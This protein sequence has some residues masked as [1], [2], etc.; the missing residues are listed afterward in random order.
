MAALV[1]S[2]ASAGSR[3]P[4]HGLTAAQVRA[5]VPAALPR[6]CRAFAEAIA[7]GADDLLDGA[8]LAELTSGKRVRGSTAKYAALRG[9][10][11]DTD[12]VAHSLFAKE[13]R[14]LCGSGV[15]PAAG[16]AGDNNE[17]GRG[18]AAAGGWSGVPASITEPALWETMSSAQLS[19]DGAI[20]VAFCKTDAGSFVIKPGR[21]TFAWREAFA[22]QIALA[23]G[24]PAPKLRVVADSD[25]EYKRIFKGLWRLSS[26]DDDLK[27]TLWKKWAHPPFVFVM[28]FVEDAQLLAGC[29]AQRAAK[30]F[31]A[32]SDG[33]ARR[34]RQLGWLVC[35]DALCNNQ[36]RVPCVHANVGNGNNV[37]LSAGGDGDVQAMDGNVHPLP[38]VSAG[39]RLRQASRG[40][41]ITEKLSKRYMTR[42]RMWLRACLQLPEEVMGEEEEEEEEE[43]GA[44]NAVGE[45]K[46][47]KGP[48]LRERTMLSLMQG[49]DAI[50]AALAEACVEA[51]QFD[52]AGSAWM[53]ASSPV[54]REYAR[55]RGVQ[56]GGAA[57]AGGIGSLVCVRDFAMIMTGGGC[58]IGE[59]GCALVREGVCAAARAVANTLTA[60]RLEQVHANTAGMVVALDGAM[61]SALR[62]C[63]WEAGRE[64]V[65][66]LTTMADLFR[67]VVR[68]AD[69]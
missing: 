57:G 41:S 42:V 47:D 8:A 7:A 28:E 15:P 59:P 54:L 58:D 24:M 18:A 37:M 34:L 52:V 9:A 30:I 16:P 61:R 21:E 53:F 25:P 38:C 66:F 63:P 29:G 6:S 22:Y 62:K 43:E 56:A 40:S 51:A 19:G 60:E 3:V 67:S 69:S 65:T 11:P 45:A 55:R 12:R 5:L 64:E 46:E 33:G 39:G 32:S 49:N 2:D 27:Y 35:M 44:V 1:S 17:A 36:D 20:G 14:A 31:D 13:I 48:S 4:L 50:N 23:L 26:A 68:L 10:V